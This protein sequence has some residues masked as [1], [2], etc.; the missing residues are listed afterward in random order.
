LAL[1]G[2][3]TIEN[4][5]NSWRLKSIPPRIREFVLDRNEA[6]ATALNVSGSDQPINLISKLISFWRTR[7][8]AR[9]VGER[10]SQPYRDGTRVAL[11]VCRK[12]S[13]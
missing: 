2:T 9:S 1:A 12:G 8:L 11:L 5:S 7:T 10:L 4:S 13:S 6:D 3:G